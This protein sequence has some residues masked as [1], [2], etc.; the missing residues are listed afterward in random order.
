MDSGLT[1]LIGSIL[2]FHALLALFTIHELI[3]HPLINKTIKSIWFLVIWLIPFVGV[4]VFRKRY[5]LE[6]VTGKYDNNTGDGG[7]IDDE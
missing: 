5:K 1:L 3:E 6:K 7:R 4:A 2:V